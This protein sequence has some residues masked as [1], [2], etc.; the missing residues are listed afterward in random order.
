M[1][2]FCFIFLLACSDYAIKNDI[3]HGPELVVYPE[4]IEFG[5]LIVGNETGQSNFAVI[6]AGDEDLIISH[7]ELTSNN[8]NFSLDLGLQE[9]YTLAP[10]ETQEFNVYYSPETYESGEAIINIVSNDEDENQKELPVS[11]FGDAPVMSVAPEIFDYGQISIGC[12]NEEKVTIRNNGNLPLIINSVTQMVTQP[13]DIIMEFG[14]LPPLPWDLLPGQE[15][16]FLVS[17][18][19]IDISYDESI[20]RIEGNDPILPLKEFFFLKTLFKLERLVF[21]DK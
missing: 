12:D 7:P 21:I 15:V 11:G 1:K 20:I 8:N 13:Q 19:P 2:Y 3:K 17:Y 10:G 18:T 14:S 16:D 4:T 9:N 6:N 5:H